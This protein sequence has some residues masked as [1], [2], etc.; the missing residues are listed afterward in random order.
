MIT[1]SYLTD[2]TY[3]I[4]GV[5]IEVHKI[6]GA[7]LLES[8]YHKCIE[9]EFKLR[10]INYKSELRIPVFYK[11]K[12]INCAFFCDF[13]IEDQIVLEIKSVSSFN[14]IHRAQVLNYINLLRK[15][16]GILVNFNVKNLYHQGQETFVNK[17][18]EMLL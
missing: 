12:E 14:E 2:L 5:C 16:K 7:G 17:Y 8:V 4:N 6:M 1:Q 13:L 18:Y 15:P 9:E 3:K 10:N 11:E